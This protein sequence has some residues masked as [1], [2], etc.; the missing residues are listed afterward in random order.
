MAVC[1][2]TAAAGAVAADRLP[3]EGDA[4][5][6]HGHDPHDGFEEGGFTGAVHADQAADTPGVQGEGGAGEGTDGT[7]VHVYVIASEK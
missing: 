4:A 2:L 3:V 1:V 6:V 7:V 5:G